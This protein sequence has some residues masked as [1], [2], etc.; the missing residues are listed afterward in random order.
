MALIFEQAEYS[1]KEWLTEVMTAAFN[2][3]TVLH[4]EDEIE[5]G[6]PGYDDGTLA[7]KMLTTENLINYI[8]LVDQKRIGFLSFSIEGSIGVLEK[9]CLLPAYIGQGFGS[10]A[11]HLLED[12]KL[13]TKWVLE[14]PDYSVKNH[15]FYEACGFVMRGKKRYGEDSYSV[16]FE[17]DYE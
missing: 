15:R 8:I 1:E 2:F 4:R 7:E 10:Q 11:W 3:D 14:T 16:V 5:D 9:F 6:P 17:K 12:R 13:C